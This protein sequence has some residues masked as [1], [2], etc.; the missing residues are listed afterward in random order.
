MHQEERFNIY[1]DTRNKSS[2]P[3]DLDCP[4]RLNV[5]KPS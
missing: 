4:K 5:L 1:L 2:F 3:L